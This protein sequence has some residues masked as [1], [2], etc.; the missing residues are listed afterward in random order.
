[1]E[2]P[3]VSVGKAAM[4]GTL[5]Y[6]KSKADASEFQNDVKIDLNPNTHVN[7]TNKSEEIL[8]SNYL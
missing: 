6:A 5:A 7:D 3:A 8:E 4:G 1:M 2:V